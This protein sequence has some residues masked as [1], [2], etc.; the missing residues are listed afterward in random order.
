MLGVAGGVVAVQAP[1]TAG[2]YCLVYELVQE[3]VT[4]FST[5][6]AAT[7]ATTVTVS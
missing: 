2:T 3:G 5:Q 7:A 6:G 4:W 1:A